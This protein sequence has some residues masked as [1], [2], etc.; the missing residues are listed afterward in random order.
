MLNLKKVYNELICKTEIDS[1]TLK[2]L[3]V[4]KGNGLKGTD[5]LRVLDGNIVKL[6][7]DDGCTTTNTIK[8]IELK[9]MNDQIH[10]N[11]LKLYTFYL[12]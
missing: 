2:N 1:Q 12:Q 6:G 8:F 9:E 7:F 3:T 11:N 10:A 4:T 5:R